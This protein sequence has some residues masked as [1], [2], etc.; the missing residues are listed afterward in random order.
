MNDKDEVYQAAWKRFYVAKP[1]PTEGNGWLRGTQ[2]VLMTSSGRLLS[3]AMKYG[4]RA[5]MAAALQEVLDAYAKLPEA[6]RRPA[7]AVTGEVQPVPAPPPGGL[8]LTIYDRPIARAPDGRYRMPQGDDLGGIRTHAP[9]GQRASL[10]LTR[11]ECQSLI[12]PDPKPGQ[13]QKVPPTLTK[14]ICLYGLWPQTLWVVEHQ[15]E[16]DS[17]RAADLNVTVDEVTPQTLRLRVHGSTLLTAM[18]RLKIYPTGKIAKELENRY[19]ARLE[20]VLVYDRAASKIVRWDMAALGDYTGAMF[21][22]RE[23]DGKRVGDDGWREATAQDPMPLGFAF[24]IDTAANAAAP[25][26][27]RPRSFVHAYIFRDREAFYW[28]PEKWAA[29]WRQRRS[30]Q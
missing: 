16:P 24:E 23:K 2:L 11:D 8:V 15:W 14:R 12:P 9:A 22:T 29:D 10:W 3:G 17:V 18:A 6:D 30:Q 5:G 28:D 4:D 27:R 20:G 19:D 26:R 25:E 7:A 1:L 21:V 13:M